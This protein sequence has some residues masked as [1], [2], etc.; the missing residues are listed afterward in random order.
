MDIM[1]TERLR[2]LRKQRGN[3]QE[4]LADFLTVSPQAVSKWERGEGLPDI[5]FL[6]KLAS[7]YN[8]TV[9]DLLGVS[10]QKKQEKIKKYLAESQRLSNAALF[11]E[12]LKLWQE[13]YSEFP[14]DETVLFNLMYAFPIKKDHA[15]EII[16][17]AERL[18]RESTNQRFRDGA[19]QQLCFAYKNKDDIEKAKEYAEMS[20]SIVTSKECLLEHI[21]EGDELKKHCSR[22]LLAYLFG[23]GNSLTSMCCDKNYARYAELHETYLRLADVY[24]DD[25]F[26]G[27]FGYS[28]L[29]RHHWLA[30]IHVGDEEKCRK[31]I[32]EAARIA[33]QYDG[34]KGDYAYTSTLMNG[35]KAHKEVR[36]YKA[37]QQ[38]SEWL[39]DSHFDFV[40]ETDWFKSILAE[41]EANK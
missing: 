40:R 39:D 22:D 33:A 19:I 31:H 35:L 9:D 25:G 1:L 3:T 28:V 14:N 10:E 32:T 20:G 12:K 24:F 5:A 30:R 38:L 13:A 8:V 27:S 7:Y 18:L 26:Y 11:D 6:P 37:V 16:S 17:L 4:E 29:M 21:Y 34:I 2:E 36:A 23:I 41:L 15:D